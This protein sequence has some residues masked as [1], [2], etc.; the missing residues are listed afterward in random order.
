MI[1][2]ARLLPRARRALPRARSETRPAGRRPA[3]V[4]FLREEAGGRHRRCSSR[5]SSRWS[6]RTGLAATATTTSGHATRGSGS[7]DLHHWVN[8]GLMALFFFVVGLEIKRELVDRRAARP[9]RGG[10]A[11]ARR[12][13]RRGAAGA[14]LRRDRRRGGE[15]AAGWAIPA[16]TDIAFAVGVLALLG[17]RVSA[18]AQLF[19]LDDRDRRRHRRDRDHRGLLLRRR[20][21]GLARAR[22][23]RLWSASSRCARRRAGVAGLRAARRRVWVAVHE[24]GV[25]ATIAGVALG[26]LTP[27]RPVAARRARRSST[28]CTRSAR[29]SSCRCSRSP[30]PAS[31]SAAACSATRS[32]S[33]LALGDRRRARASASS[34]GDLRGATLLALR[35]GWGDAA[36]RRARA[37]RSSGVGGARRAS[38]SP[39]RCSSPSSRST[40]DRRSSSRRRSASSPARSRAACSALRCCSRRGAR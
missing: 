29:S 19:L 32:A 25:H 7:L 1:T 5:R 9:P 4:E 13:R 10:A 27:A 11:G 24:S 39:S 40:D 34:L 8:D 33:R 28:A 23:P 20:R 2:R 37:G 22:P 12:A 26:L 3:P 6:G 15:G 30:T 36:R 35:V 14:H 31:T 38:A 16:A 18:G 17:D 21:A